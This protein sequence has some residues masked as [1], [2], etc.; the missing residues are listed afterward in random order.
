M[1][2]T[3]HLKDLE[4]AGGHSMKQEGMYIF[5]P[6]GDLTGRVCLFFCRKELI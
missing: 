4:R 2:E 6:F 5:K 1:S 3:H